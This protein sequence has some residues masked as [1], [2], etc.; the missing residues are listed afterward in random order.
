MQFI[1]YW[2]NILKLTDIWI[3]SLNPYGLKNNTFIK[4]FISPDLIN[5][6]NL[7]EKYFERK[8]ENNNSK[9]FFNENKEYIFFAILI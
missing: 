8:K 1:I 5:S 6:I 9:E 7:N 3:I 4:N 2:K